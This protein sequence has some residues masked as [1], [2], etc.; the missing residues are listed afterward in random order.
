MR[1]KRWLLFIPIG[2][3]LAM[4]GILLLA[5][6]SML[7][8][9]ETAAT[10][11]FLN[12]GIRLDDPTTQII[13]G[14]VLILLGGF[15]V[16]LAVNRLVGSIAESIAPKQTKKE[17]VDVVYKQRFLSQGKRVVVIGGGTGLSTMLRGLK[18]YTSNI[19]AIVTVTDNGGSSGRLHEE[20]GMIPPGDIR[21][22][23]VALS[24]SEDLMTD[25]LRY[26]FKDEI[27]GIEGHSFGNLLIAVMTKISGDF[28]TAVREAGKILAIRGQV[29]PSTTESVDLVAEMEDGS[30]IRGETQITESPLKIKRIF[31]SNPDAEPLP[32]ALEAI[33]EADCVILGPGSVFTSIIPNL[34]VRGITEALEETDALTVYIC[35]V[36][37][38]RGETDGFRAS[39][40]IRAVTRNSSKDVFT[41][42][43]VNTTKPGEELLKRYEKTGQQ[44]VVPDVMRVRGMGY[45]PVTGSFINESNVVRHDCN[46]L[47]YTIFKLLQDR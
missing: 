8:I 40:H 18:R 44:F 7:G 25:L 6:I 30:K 17:L 28:E 20:M 11:T 42:V 12:F 14:S 34:T 29:L 2:V 41:H 35:N 16:T 13:T 32:E 9:L 19:T 4:A 36:M 24:D 5:N 45:K 15:C 3:L 43:L 39:D 26:R 38:Q 10:W 37:T 22:C 33:K 31:L 23:I 21:N 1:V 27:K 46:R 47:A